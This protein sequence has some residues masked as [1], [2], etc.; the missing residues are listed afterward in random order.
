[1]K[2]LIKKIS[3]SW[4]IAFLIFIHFIPPAFTQY[5]VAPKYLLELGKQFYLRGQYKDA[6]EEFEKALLINPDLEEA[7]VS[8][9]FSGVVE[10]EE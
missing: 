10:R 4:I 8:V 7:Q 2:A 6:L 1:M 3:L 5:R 9:K